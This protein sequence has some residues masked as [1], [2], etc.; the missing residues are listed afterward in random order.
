M[1]D[2]KVILITGAA[3]KIGSAITKSLFSKDNFL[4]LLDINKKSLKNLTSDFPIEKFLSFSANSSNE[5]DMQFVIQESIKKFGKIDAAIHSAY[6]KSN[7]WGARFEELNPEYLYQDL[8]SHLGG[9]IIFSKLILKHFLNQ[10]FGN[11]VH[12][13][14]IQGTSS[15]KFEHY[16][17]TNMV[18]PIE[19]SA[20]KAGIISIT[21]YLAK[22]YKNNN[23]RINCISPGGIF[24]NQPEIFLTKYREEC[25]LK[26]LLNSDDI[27]DTVYFLISDMSKYINGQN[28]IVDD[29]W[30]L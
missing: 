22:Y 21:K 12:F 9:A 8:T 24:D 27:C 13:S 3:G 1:T 30:S 16:E 28:I 19:Y 14:S 29:G 5:N 6:P 23:I 20:I 2:Q 15:P 10:G 4:I 18:S 25:N 7:K 26:G 11:L 17:G